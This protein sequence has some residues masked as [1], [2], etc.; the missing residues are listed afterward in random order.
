[1]DFK[2]D[3]ILED[4]KK[5]KASILAELAP[6]EKEKEELM[7]QFQPI[8]EKL[9]AVRKKIADIEKKRGLA[10]LSRTIVAIGRTKPG[11]KTLIAEPAH[12]GAKK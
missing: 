2:I 8:D 10:D 5:E 7:K 11:T 9:R 1:M 6:F 4:A 12:F 3:K